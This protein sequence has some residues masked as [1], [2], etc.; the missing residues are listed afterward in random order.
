MSPAKHI[1]W[2]LPSDHARDLYHLHIRNRFDALSEGELTPS[3]YTNIVFEEAQ[4]HGHGRARL[5]GK[6]HIKNND[7]KVDEL[8]AL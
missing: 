1:A 8:L 6:L 3:Q 4:V 5:T 7:G 2:R